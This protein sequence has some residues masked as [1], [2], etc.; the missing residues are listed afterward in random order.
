MVIVSRCLICGSKVD[1]PIGKGR[2]R[3]C[4]SSRCK[5]VAFRRR[6]ASAESAWM[7]SPSPS[8]RVEG[9]DDAEEATLEAALEELSGLPSDPDEAVA[10]ALAAGWTAVRMFDRCE[11]V[12][13]REFAWHCAEASAAIAAVLRKHFE[14][15]GG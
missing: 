2:P 13:R 12:A 9:L 10:V 11:K 3:L 15:D 8:P 1:Q 5:M 6:R 7:V 4:C 14:P